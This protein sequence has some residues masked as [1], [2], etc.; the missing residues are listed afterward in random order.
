MTG[1]GRDAADT[2]RKALDAHGWDERYAGREL[3]WS[4][5]PNRFVAEEV[6]AL[7]TGR[8]L[9]LAAGEGRNAVWLA[10]RGWEVTAVDFSPVG[11]DK[12]RQLASRRGVEVEW[13]LADL[14][15]WRPDTGAFDLVLVAYLHVGADLLHRILQRSADA[16]APGGTLLAI[17]HDVANLDGGHGGPQDP[18]VLYTVEELRRA[19]PGLQIHRAAQV[20]RAVELD[21]GRTAT[22]IDTLVRAARPPADRS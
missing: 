16:L 17:G 6:A 10:E 20:R 8:A 21:D 15:E 2:P 9:D 12:A 14:A 13:I 22:A 18:A 4:A 7:P 1:S 19:L 5:E 3:L 11:L